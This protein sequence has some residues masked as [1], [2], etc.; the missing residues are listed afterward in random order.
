MKQ[1]T[2]A[3]FTLYASHYYENAS[4]TDE[5]EFKEDLNHVKYIKRLFN[6]Y[7]ETGELKERLILNHL[8]IVYNVFQSDAATKMLCFKLS[9]Y[10]PYLK[11]FLM[12]LSFWPA[13]V[14][15]VGE[16]NETIL[17]SD[18]TLDNFIIQRLRE[19]RRNG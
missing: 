8:I 1:V 16:Q 10:L 14:E 19:I 6:K 12:F 17:D 4:C 2:E 15:G 11:T 13:R 18:I 3:N 9:E 5:L 7:R